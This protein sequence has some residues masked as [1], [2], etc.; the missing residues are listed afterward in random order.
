MRTNFLHFCIII[1]SLLTVR[2]VTAVE[3]FVVAAAVGISVMSNDEL[4]SDLLAELLF[5]KSVTGT[6]F[7]VGDDGPLMHSR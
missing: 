6:G 2:V 3:A 5:D 1:S 7:S 4:R